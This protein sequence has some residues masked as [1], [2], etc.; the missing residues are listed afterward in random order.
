MTDKKVSKKSRKV[1]SVAPPS[2]TLV[3]GK[4]EKEYT[5]ESLVVE[6]GKFNQ[7]PIGVKY[8]AP[9]VNK[10]AVLAYNSA[11]LRG[12]TAGILLVSLSDPN[13]Q[14]TTIRLSLDSSNTTCNHIIAERVDDNGNP[15]KT[16]SKKT[17]TMVEK[18]ESEGESSEE[19]PKKI[20]KPTKKVAKKV[21]D[22]ESESE[23][24]LKKPI[25]PAKKV[26]KK[27]EEG[28]VKKVVK[29]V[30]ESESESEDEPVKPVK[31]V[32]KKTVVKSVK[33]ASSESEEEA[34]KPKKTA[35]V[36]KKK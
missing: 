18:E 36:A 27:V 21:E 23:E 33:E 30:E 24:Q 1:E 28:A 22:S 25:K 14:K 35:K 2:T 31:K 20:V 29:K 19:Q 34:P 7:L 12:E 26:A 9:D 4:G 5:L 17:P 15:G 13:G 32:V 16:K 11:L 8:K 6:E 3:F 10:A